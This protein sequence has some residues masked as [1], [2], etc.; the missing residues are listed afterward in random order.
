MGFYLD[1]IDANGAA[2]RAGWRSE[3]E[4]NFR[5]AWISHIIENIGFTALSILDI[6]CADG[7][8]VNKINPRYK[9]RYVGVESMPHFLQKARL[10]HPDLTFLEGDFREVVLPKS[11]LVVALGTTI[12]ESA[13]VPLHAL[14]EAAYRADAKVI[15]L[16]TVAGFSV[17]P[18]LVANPPPPLAA[19]WSR[20]F[21]PPISGEHIWVD[22]RTEI[23]ET[24]AQTL[25][26]DARKGGHESPG[27]TAMLAARLGLRETVHELASNH[28]ND[29]HVHLAVELLGAI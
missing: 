22:S 28:P 3:I 6:G 21:C 20:T 18:A 9:S 7:A 10:S 5:F 26:E 17:D 15:A 16:S 23:P 25:F 1:K 14:Y 29:E 2:Q 11:D 13:P 4:R 12:G 27:P 8:L 24:D 19:G